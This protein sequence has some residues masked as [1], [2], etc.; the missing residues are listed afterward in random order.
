MTFKR[1]QEFKILRVSH[2]PYVFTAC[3]DIK[4]PFQKVF[5]TS[6]K[7]K[8]PESFPLHEGIIFC[9]S[10]RGFLTDNAKLKRDHY[11]T[12]DINQSETINLICFAVM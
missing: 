1:A 11:N 5:S 8:S 10:Q 2:S 6:L 3:V 9:L 7:F 4:L 12:C